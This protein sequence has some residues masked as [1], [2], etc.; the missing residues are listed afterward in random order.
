MLSYNESQL[1][2]VSVCQASVGMPSL[3]LTEPSKFSSRRLVMTV[4]IGYCIAY[5]HY[6]A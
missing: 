4:I 3:N 6:V 2:I 5:V 1:Q